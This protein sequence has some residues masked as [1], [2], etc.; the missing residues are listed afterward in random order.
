LKNEAVSD[1]QKRELRKLRTDELRSGL[2][3]FAGAY[4]D[5]L[6]ADPDNENGDEIITAIALIHKTISSL[7]LNTNENLALHALLLKCPPLRTL[8]NITQSN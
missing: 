5:L 1:R 6:R 7:G 4:K 8:A 2:S 3:I